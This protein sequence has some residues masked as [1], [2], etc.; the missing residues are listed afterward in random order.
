[1]SDLTAF[2]AFGMALLGLLWIFA[3]VCAVFV[4]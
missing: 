3:E 1:M 2:V 4:P